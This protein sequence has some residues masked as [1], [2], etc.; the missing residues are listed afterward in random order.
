LG[1]AGLARLAAAQGRAERAGRLFGAAAALFPASG[2][3]FDGTDRAAFDRHVAE[4]RAGL[5][6]AAFGAGWAAGQALPPEQAVAAA[7]DETPIDRGGPALPAGPKGQ[8][9]GL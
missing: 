6:P 1:L 5:D 3:L 8:R 4:A 9:G 2:R 7:L